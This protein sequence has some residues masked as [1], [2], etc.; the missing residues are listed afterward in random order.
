[1]KTNLFLVGAPKTG[2]TSLYHYLA[3]HPQIFMCKD[4]EPHYFC[5]D[6][7]DQCIKHHGNLIKFPYTSIAQY[8]SLFSSAKNSPIIGEASTSYLYSKTAAKNIHNYNPNAK[9][10]VI[11]RNPIQL[12]HSWYHYINYT[13]EEPSKTFEQALLLESHRI[14][15]LNSIPKSVWYPARV[16]YRELVQFDNQLRK[17]YDLFDYKNIKIVLTED[18]TENPIDVYNEI[19]NFLNVDPYTPNFKTHNIYQE[20]RFKKLK[21]FIDNHL[22]KLKS[23]VRN[24]R[25][26]K[27][28][29][30]LENSYKY[31]MG[32]DSKRSII[33]DTLLTK[34]KDEL[35]PMVQRTG[36][37]INKD[38]CK[39]WEFHEPIDL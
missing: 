20:I 33:N 39:K 18:L 28:V 2:S 14:N 29:K 19:L 17:Y 9:I 37:L 24:N 5:S 25:D 38:L 27:I 26:T 3:E 23:V 31:T 7:H 30:L 1:M 15:E 6:F 11:L 8:N 16:F 21:W 4:K 10:I 22:T 32:K 13:S 34:L 36:S 35:Q 12:M